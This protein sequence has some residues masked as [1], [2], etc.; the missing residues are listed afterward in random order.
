MSDCDRIADGETRAGR[1]QRGDAPPA[2]T[3]TKS[4][5]KAAGD[6]AAQAARDWDGTG[7][8]DGAKGRQISRTGR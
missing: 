8:A 2:S 6:S 4:H 3:E 7:D 1:Q 5:Q